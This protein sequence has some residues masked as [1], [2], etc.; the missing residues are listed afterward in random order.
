MTAVSTSDLLAVRAALAVGA[1]PAE[2]LGAAATGDLADAARAVRL[3]WPLADAAR[4]AADDGAQGAGPVLRALALVERCGH[5]GVA[6]IDMALEA[7]HDA[8]VDEQRLAAKAA[9]AAGTAKLLTVLPLAAWVLLVALD[10]AA[11]GFYATPV[12]WGCA[13]ATVVL[14]ATGQRWAHRLVAAAA[15]TAD[16][17]DPLARP[18]AP[19]DRLRAAVVAL[20]LAVALWVVAHPLVAVTAAG[21][22]AARV[23]RAGAGAEPP[24]CHAVEVLHL[25]RMAL[26]ADTGV[27][28]ALEHVADVVAPPVDGLLRGIA[29]RLRSGAAIA[30]AF[31]GTPLAEAGTV[32]DITER[33]GVAATAPLAQLIAALR[34]RRRGAAEAAAERVQLALVFPTTLLTLPAFVLAVVPP[35]VWTALAG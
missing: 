8:L 24:P 4:A 9:Q 19:F 28:G 23:G 27:A 25:M 20:P 10:R 33:W 35:L 6:A 18:A 21:L 32:L 2:A 29:G 5:G 11:L 7:R 14:A 22:V 3:G 1:A 13:A 12:G 30:D 15:A 17:A 26:A 34:A 16:L 31:A